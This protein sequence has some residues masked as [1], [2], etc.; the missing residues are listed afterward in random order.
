MAY[1][2][3]DPVIEFFYEM[4]FS[5]QLLGCH[6]IALKFLYFLKFFGAIVRNDEQF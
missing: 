6:A 4:V 5:S 1:F 3:G 2:R